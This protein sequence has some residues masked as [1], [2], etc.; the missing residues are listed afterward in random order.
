[1]KDKIKKQIEKEFLK[2]RGWKDWEEY[3]KVGEHSE[4]DKNIRKELINTSI[5]ITIK[6]VL[7]KI[8]ELERMVKLAQT[9]KEVDMGKT[10][11][12]IHILKECSQV[13]RATNLLEKK[14]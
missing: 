1:M 6:E 12:Q 10:D 5:D 9:C 2:I 8:D 14:Q 3:D 4:L 7:K 11:A 13:I